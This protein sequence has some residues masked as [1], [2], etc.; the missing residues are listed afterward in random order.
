MKILVTGA[1]GL[2][3]RR[4]VSHLAAN[5]HSLVAVTRSAK[6]FGGN[7]QIEIIETDLATRPIETSR[8]AG[9]DAAVHLAGESVAGARW[10]EDKK[11]RIFES[12]VLA[13]RHLVESL[14]DAT[15]K[16]LVSA[17]AI[18]IYGDRGD[19]ILSEESHPG[20]GFLSEVARCWEE[21]ARSFSGRLC[22]LRIAL[23]L[24]REGGALEK[25]VPLFRAG[26]GGPMGHGKQWMSWIHIDDLVA[27]ITFC[28]L[29]NDV[30]GVFNAAAPSP[31][32]N[33]EFTRLLATAVRRPAVF[34]VPRFAL[35]VAMGEM[36]ELVLASQR[37][38][39]R[40]A[41][42]SGFDFQF[43]QLEPALRD[44]VSS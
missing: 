17:S 4:L 40:H 7:S 13:T 3:G 1:S 29:H 20:E 34:A 27:L 35:R 37:V 32:Q 10:S 44:V 36:A 41:E 19:E 31:V 2:V 16:T 23:V 25:L 24:A 38:L 5:G 43:T 22:L 33:K 18:G 14:N 42:Q 9:V 21:E 26:L 28:L 8:L 15:V 11:R 12:R 6:T 39:P 30:K